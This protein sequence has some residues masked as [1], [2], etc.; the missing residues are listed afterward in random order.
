MACAEKGKLKGRE[1]LY[2]LKQNQPV[3]LIRVLAVKPLFLLLSEKNK[4]RASD[5]L[6]GMLEILFQLL[7][8]LHCVLTSISRLPWITATIHCISF[9]VKL[10]VPGGEESPASNLRHTVASHREDRNTGFFWAH[11]FELS[12]LTF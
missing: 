4:R 7:R 8:Q 10:A 12:S 3:R 2:K 9:K 11:L 6:T 1:E 5:G